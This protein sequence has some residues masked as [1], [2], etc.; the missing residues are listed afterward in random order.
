MGKKIAIF[1]FNDE[2]MCFAHA[3]MDAIDM[4]VFAVHAPRRWI[5]LK[6]PKNRV[7]AFVM[8]CSGI[9]V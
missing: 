7:F 6:A 8:R 1:A 3:L 4:T 5:T 2:P 9:Q